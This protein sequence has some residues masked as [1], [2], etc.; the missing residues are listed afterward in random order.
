MI[1]F[2]S[3]PSSESYIKKNKDI[4]FCM[5]TSEKIR[6]YHC[7]VRWNKFRIVIDNY[8]F[9][10]RFI[11]LSISGKSVFFSA[12]KK[13]LNIFMV[14]ASMVRNLNSTRSQCWH[15]RFSYKISVGQ[16]CERL[17]LVDICVERK[18][19]NFWKSIYF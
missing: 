3:S 5:Y 14:Y 10:I 4:I 6:T 2:W 16:I 13:F 15:C 17:S 18:C 12:E 1:H 8:R 7:I 9:R 19:K 11:T